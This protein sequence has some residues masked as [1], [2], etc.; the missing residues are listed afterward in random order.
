MRRHHAERAHWR[1]KAL[2]ARWQ[3]V[4]AKLQAVVTLA[5]TWIMFLFLLQERRT[6]TLPPSS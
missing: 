4:I 1:S 3:R 6:A 5:G 2:L